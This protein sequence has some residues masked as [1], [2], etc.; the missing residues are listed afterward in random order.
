[1]STIELN[2]IVNTVPEN[3][4]T[5]VVNTN[6]VNTN[7]VNTNMV[8]TSKPTP[9]IKVVVHNNPTITDIFNTVVNNSTFT[10]EIENFIKTVQTNGKL[11][12]LDI[13]NLVLLVMDCID[14]TASFKLSNA[15]L[16]VL[17]KMIYEYIIV[18]Y[19]L[20]PVEDRPAYEIMFLTSVNLIMRQPFQKIKKSFLS[21][22]KCC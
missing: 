12:T 21:L 7:V 1:M 13:P 20:L 8:T 17:L 9:P 3:V 11:T 5:N 22:F 14:G 6:V 15:T 19:N 18:K 16:P 10:S 2:T 4:T